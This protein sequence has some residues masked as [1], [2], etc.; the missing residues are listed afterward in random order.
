MNTPKPCDS[1]VHV[2]WDVMGEDDP[3]ASVWCNED[4][5]AKRWGDIRCPLYERHP[6]LASEV[7]IHPQDEGLGLLD[8]AWKIKEE[9]LEKSKRL[10]GEGLKLQAESNGV[11][12]NGFRLQREGN[13]LCSEGAALLAK[14]EELCDE[15]KKLLVKGKQKFSGAVIF[16]YGEGTT[17]EWSNDNSACTIHTSKSFEP[18]KGEQK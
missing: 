14:S 12:L 17:L 7:Q 16:E 2:E 11:Y 8:K 6:T 10:H 15:S 3:N 1:C 13:K 18:K 4:D 5:A 9:L